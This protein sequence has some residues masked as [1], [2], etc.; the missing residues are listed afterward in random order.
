MFR[1]MNRTDRSLVRL[2]DSAVDNLRDGEDAYEVAISMMGL[3]GGHVLTDSVFGGSAYQMWAEI[4][5]LLDDPKGPESH[6]MCEAAASYVASEWKQG[7]QGVAPSD[8]AV[9]PEDASSTLIGASA[10]RNAHAGASY[11]RVSARS[12]TRAAMPNCRDYAHDV[13]RELMR[14]KSSSMPVAPDAADVTALRVWHCS[15]KSL[16]QLAY[17]SNLRILAIASYPD[18]DLDSVAKLSSLEH[19]SIL[20]LPDVHDLRPLERLPHLHTLRLATLPS[21]D[22]SGKVTIVD[23]LKPLARIAGLKHLE[24]FGVRPTTKS[25]EELEAAPA[26]ISVR[27]SKYPKPE[28]RRFYEATQLSDKFAPDPDVP[29]WH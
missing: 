19:L 4:S 23:S 1:R 21:W 18:K 13:F 29:D 26:L 22:S 3:L 16:A 9:L 14:D 7:R 28:V 17:Y 6:R 11:R 20:H 2:M 12:A 5:D 25:L 10:L 27:V 15:Y 8:R 24:L